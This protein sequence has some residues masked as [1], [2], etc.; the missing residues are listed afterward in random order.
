LRDFFKKFVFPAKMSDVAFTP[1]ALSEL[2][3]KALKQ[4]LSDR[5]LKVGGRKAELIERLLAYEP[6]ACSDAAESNDVVSVQSQ[7]DVVASVHSELLLSSSPVVKKVSLE[8]QASVCESVCDALIGDV[9]DELVVGA[10]DEVFDSTLDEEESVKTSLEMYIRQSTGGADSTG[11]IPRPNDQ[12]QDQDDEDIDADDQEDEQQQEQETAVRPNEP[13]VSV[14]V[15]VMAPVT[16]PQPDPAPAPA[17]AQQPVRISSAAFAQSLLSPTM[18]I[19]GGDNL[20]MILHTASGMSSASIS[21]MESPYQ[22]SGAPSASK[23]SQQQQQAQAASPT[24]EPAGV[25]RIGARVSAMVK[26]KRQRGTVKYLGVTSFEKGE[27]CGLQLDDAVGNH[28][29]TVQSVRYFYCAPKHGVFVRPSA[30]TLIDE[31]APAPAPAKKTPTSSATASQTHSAGIKPLS[32]KQPTASNVDANAAPSS[33][34]SSSKLAVGQ[35]VAIKGRGE[36]AVIMYIGAVKFAEDG[37]EWVGLQLKQATGKN[38][39]SVKGE[40]YFECAPKHGLF[41]RPNAVVPLT[42]S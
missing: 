10:F 37:G 18:L 22:P 9:V 23:P 19:S 33:G 15:P 34:S 41:V 3:V 27:W 40:R 21:P 30:V 32:A 14:P 36:H 28:D 8:A 42:K 16:K 1:E 25:L 31:S 11:E 35:R 7:S 24:V 17:P 4:L 6:A 29:G 12:D 39:G 20:P 5:G 13:A 2:T 38:D 26:D